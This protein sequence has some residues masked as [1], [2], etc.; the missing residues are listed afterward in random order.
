MRS[1]RTTKAVFD[2]TLILEGVGT[3]NEEGV[4]ALFEA[5][6]DDA[7]PAMRNGVAFLEFSREAVSFDEAV[8]SAIRNVE[9]AGFPVARVEPDDFV[10]MSEIARRLKRTRESIRQLISGVRGPGGFPP[11]L[12]RVRQR[13]PLWRW[14]E[15]LQW[16]QKTRERKPAKP[17]RLQERENQLLA[18]RF[19]ASVNDLLDLRRNVQ[20]AAQAHHLYQALVVPHFG[21]PGNSKSRSED[22][23]VPS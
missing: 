17:S 23:E 10:N 21:P 6:C 8:L 13:S 9:K 14:T 15:V 2:F 16:V 19:V 22:A 7:L 12:A 11:P 1:K 3:L 5:G 18:S 20:T 4:N